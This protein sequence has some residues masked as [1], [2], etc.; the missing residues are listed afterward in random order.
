MK[1]EKKKL[2]FFLESFSGGGAETVLLRI[3]KYIDRDKFDVVIIVM[4]P[5][6]ELRSEFYKLGFKIKN[7]INSKFLILNKI[8]YK[9]LYS[10]I[11]DYIVC[12]YLIRGLK[13]DTY[14]AFTEGYTTKIFSKIKNGETKI[15]WVHIDLE[16]Y[17][18]TQ[19]TKIYKGLN[20]EIEIYKRFNKVVAVSV[21]VAKSL[22]TYY[23]IPTP[24]IIH[25]PIDEQQIRSLS[26]AKH[27]IN[28]DKNK[29]N[30]VTVGRLVIQKG[31]NQLINVFYEISKGKQ[32]AMLWIIGEGPE[33][34]N[35]ETKIGELKLRE[36]VMMP[37]YIRNP[38]PLMK[39]M[40]LFVC[41]SLAEGFS[42]VIA[43][44]MVL[45]LPVVSMNC[46]GPDELTE[47]GK[48]G[49][50]CDTYSQLKD[51]ILEIISNKKLIVELRQKSLERSKIF[52]TEK[53]IREIEKLF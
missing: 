40:D 22:Q 1:M 34:K 17:P 5:K 18:W 3:L 2:V 7:V 8:K 12:R 44:A 45:G 53:T 43:E 14:I 23:N 36:K 32:N 41:S 26:M 25:N 6:G 52:E 15:T 21:S 13:A 38:F 28:I 47:W 37:G 11:P 20:E 24:T 50:L 9:L 4:T 48:Y 27:A 16:K 39:D 42:L 49:I 33:R 51:S 35:L 10:F 19:N 31:Y 29:F 30:I 46:A